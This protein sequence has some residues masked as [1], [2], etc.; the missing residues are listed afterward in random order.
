ME[1]PIGR[2]L[3]IYLWWMAII[4]GDYTDVHHITG[5]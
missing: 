3:L 5:L 1:Y 2:E 4:I